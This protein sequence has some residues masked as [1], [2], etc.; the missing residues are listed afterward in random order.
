[1]FKYHFA[2][3]E[4]DPLEFEVDESAE[5]SLEDPDQPVPDWVR[6]ERFRCEHCTLPPG[7][8]T[9]CPA[10]LAIQPI[11]E[12]FSRRFSFDT[13]C[14]TVQVNELSIE[15]ALSNQAAVRSLVG[16][17]LA[18]SAC[19]VL[20]KLRPMANYHLPFGSREHTTFRFLGMYLIAQYIRHREGL[21]AEWDL[22]GLNELLDSV[23]KVNSHLADRIRAASEADAAVNSLVFLDAFAY[24]VQLKI[25]QSLDTLREIF[26][27]Y[28]E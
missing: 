4:E 17:K 24:D 21:S 6:L 27:G 19:P 11:V 18:L 28:M 22:K 20:K 2:F 10:A 26:R 13:T 16:L 7:S 15:A 3:E 14:A 23:H 25:E 8:R 12:A 1:M 9:A 5:T